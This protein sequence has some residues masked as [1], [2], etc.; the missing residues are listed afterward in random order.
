MSILLMMS[1]LFRLPIEV[2]FTASLPREFSFNLECRV[3]RKPTVLRLNVKAGGYTVKMGLTF[4]SAGGD[5]VE[6]PVQSQAN[7]TIS[8]GQVKLI[9][10]N[11]HVYVCST[12]M[13]I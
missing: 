2:S 1:F 8:F 11:L 4:T 3:K 5:E 9:Q 6:V 10:W 12:Y 13:Y 7:R